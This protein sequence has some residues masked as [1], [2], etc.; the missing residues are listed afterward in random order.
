M[1]DSLSF[2]SLSTPVVEIKSNNVTLTSVTNKF[3]GIKEK[4]VFIIRY[5]GKILKLMNYNTKI[6]SNGVN[7]TNLNCGLFSYFKTE[8]KS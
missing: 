4:S 7:P 2:Y 8:F 6:C 5:A 1:F 3:T